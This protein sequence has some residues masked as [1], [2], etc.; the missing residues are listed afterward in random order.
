MCKCNAKAD[1]AE[2]DRQRLATKRILTW[3][4][5]M[6]ARQWLAL[7]DDPDFL[8]WLEGLTEDQEELFLGIKIAPET[9]PKAMEAV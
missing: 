1:R 7:Q 4:K 8:D 3:A 5:T 6:T 2:A 9:E